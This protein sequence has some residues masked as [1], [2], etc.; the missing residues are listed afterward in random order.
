M[1]TSL[2]EQV[3]QTAGTLAAGTDAHDDLTVAAHLE[4]TGYAMETGIAQQEMRVWKK[5]LH[6]G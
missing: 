3:N 5:R 4:D 6:K 2:R 1:R